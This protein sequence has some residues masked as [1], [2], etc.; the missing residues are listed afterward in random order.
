MDRI[1]FIEDWNLYVKGEEANFES[2][3]AEYLV[4]QGIAEYVDKEKSLDSPPEDKMFRR[5]RS[6]RKDVHNLE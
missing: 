6:R 5:G 1:R 3:I 2:V 4:N